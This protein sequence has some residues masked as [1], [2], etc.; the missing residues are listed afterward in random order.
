VKA[1]PRDASQPQS[2]ATNI[3]APPSA[4][5]ATSAAAACPSGEASPA[6][7]LDSRETVPD[8]RLPGVLTG[9]GAFM[10]AGGMSP[11]SLAIA[12]MSL[13]ELTSSS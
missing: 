8:L 9:L 4:K 6:F 7:S 11:L 10:L 3:V 2:R 12:S 13:P 5:F 1:V